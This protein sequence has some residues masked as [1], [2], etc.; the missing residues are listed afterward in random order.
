MLGRSIKITF[1][2]AASLIFT[3]QVFVATAAPPQQDN[4]TIAD[5]AAGD[6]RFTTLVTA[7]QAVGL[8]ETLQGEG[9]FTVFAPTNEAFIALPPG[10]LDSLLADIPALND[11]LRYHVVSGKLLAADVVQLSSFDTVLGEPVSIAVENGVVR[12]NN[13]QIIVTDIEAS[14]GVI[15]VIDTVLL[16]PTAVPAPAPVPTAVP[17]PTPIP[18][19]MLSPAPYPSQPGYGQ[20]ADCVYQP[21]SCN[22]QWYSSSGRL[23]GH[24]HMYGHVSYGPYPYGFYRQGSYSAGGYR[25]WWHTR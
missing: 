7:L 22:Y 21:Y 4:Q 1:I 12:I 13:A 24:N 6:S 15:H 2:L 8:T 25:Y 14:N 9:P 20:Q 10:T 5:I 23:P 18:P 17:A 16:R 11:T 3:W 19:V